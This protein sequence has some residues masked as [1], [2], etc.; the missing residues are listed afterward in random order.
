MGQNASGYVFNYAFP[1]S[2]Q[3]S[4]TYSKTLGA[5]LQCRLLAS[6][7]QNVQQSSQKWVKVQPCAWGS[8]SLSLSS[9]DEQPLSS[10]FTWSRNNWSPIW[11][12][13]MNTSLTLSY[14]PT[15]QPW[16]FHRIS[17]LQTFL[18][19]KKQDKQE[20][21]RENP[22]QA[23]Q[24]NCTAVAQLWLWFKTIHRA[25]RT[26]HAGLRQVLGMWALNKLV[27][28]SHL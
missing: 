8:L 4:C 25:S 5:A 22:K 23:N 7:I 21:Q 24:E 14:R 3:H 17:F 18:L 28:I 10:T 1:L 9:N 13:Y 26:A 27:G 16:K 11:A 2:L 6:M 20:S 12:E 19:L 15:N